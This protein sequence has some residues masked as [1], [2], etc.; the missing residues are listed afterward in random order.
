MYSDLNVLHY[1][2]RLV[3]ILNELN[4]I[5]ASWSL[6][7]PILDLM[8]VL[9][10]KRVFDLMTRWLYTIRVQSF[11]YV[12]LSN[13]SM[14]VLWDEVVPSSSSFQINI[15]LYLFLENNHFPSNLVF[16]F[17]MFYIYFWIN[18]Y[19]FVSLTTNRSICKFI[20]II[21]YRLVVRVRLITF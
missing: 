14:F 13:D 18:I 7:L 5:V 15:L 1:M 21:C 11:T 4:Q 17:D 6:Q 12:Y 8:F 16:R 10:L 20:P 9:C 2:W 19:I 3:S